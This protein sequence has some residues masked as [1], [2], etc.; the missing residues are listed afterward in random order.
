MLLWYEIAQ[1][2]LPGYLGVTLGRTPT[3]PQHIKQV[4]NAIN[5][6][7]KVIQGLTGA[8]KTGNIYE[9]AFLLSQTI[10]PPAQC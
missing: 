7:V 5:S 10:G 6:C 3:S 1:E 2:P 9:G 8:R 4:S